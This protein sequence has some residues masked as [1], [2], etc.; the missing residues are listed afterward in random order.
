MS[1]TSISAN[2][3]FNLNNK[4]VDAPI[5]WEDISIDANFEDG[6]VQPIISIDS[7][8]FVDKEAQEIRDWISSGRIFEGIPFK[9]DAYNINT[10]KNSFDGYINCADG[11]ELHEDTTVNANVEP[12]GLTNV[13]KRL[14]GITMSYLEGI[15]VFTQADYTSV[16]YVVEK[17]NNKMEVLMNIVV[18]FMLSVQL[19]QQ[20][21][22]TGNSIATTAGIVAAGISGTVG[23]AIYA[24][25]STILNIIFTV[26]MITAIITLSIQ[27][28][29][30]LLPIPRT[31]KTLGLRTALTKIANHLGYTFSS[32]IALLDDLVYLPSN[33]ETDEVN[34]LTG[35]INF[36]KG[37]KTGLP[38]ERDYGFTGLEFFEL[39]EK[40][41]NADIKVNGTTLEFRSRNDPYWKQAPTYQMP[42]YLL[43]VKRF[44]TD[45]LVFSRLIRFDTDEIADE[46]TLNNFKGTNYEIITNDTTIINSE[47]KY[48]TKHETISIPVA[49][50]NRKDSLNGLENSLADLAGTVDDV[51][52]FFGG[53]SNLAGKI[54]SRIGVL[55]VGTNNTTKPKLLYVKGGKLPSNHRTMFSAKVL[56]NLYINEKSFVLNNF[57]GQKALYKLE[58]LPFGFD[59]FLNTIE[60]SNFVDSNNKLAK[61][62]SLNWL[63]SGDT[64][65]G[66]YEQKEIYTTT[67][68][69]TYIE[70][71]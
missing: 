21:E 41:F 43:K 50:G 63:I 31:H 40:I 70:A 69:E 58:D 56:Y 61:F 32:P 34:L 27:I 13:K 62:R 66:E 35:F 5:E 54:T 52:N 53:S 2:L 49:L 60:N 19:K 6:G 20:V 29:E 65:E 59:N 25:A 37:T 57:G 14:S 48:I 28:F 23:A 33:L 39:C 67:L 42:N 17:S 12:K 30:A 18:A 44:N 3:R 4:V 11:V 7:F 15:G 64:A 36:P 16:K 51:I 22:K 45:E 38:N 71:Q 1:Q 47:A 10:S 9:I 46:W 68:T 8:T 26:F 24:V 55:K